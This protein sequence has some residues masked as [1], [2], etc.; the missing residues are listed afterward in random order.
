M[1]RTA[2]ARR[3]LFAPLRGDSAQIRPPYTIDEE[4]FLERCTRCGACLGA[5]PTGLLTKGH[6]GFPIADFA[7]GACTFCGACAKACTHG[8]LDLGAMPPWALRATITQGC[9]ERHK[10]T[11]RRC[12]ETCPAS[13]IK[14]SPILGGG[15]SPAILADR[16]TGCGAC[17]SCCPVNAIAIAPPALNEERA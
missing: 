14:F 3:A 4:D 17:V 9:V 2:A 8:C 12:A 16:C 5:C 15:S 7:R 13:A 6:G 11:C 10:V 1:S